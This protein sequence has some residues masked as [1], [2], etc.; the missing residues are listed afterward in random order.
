[1][2]ASTVGGREHDRSL[3]GTRTNMPIRF[4]EVLSFTIGAANTTSGTVDIRGHTFLGLRIP[5]SFTGTQLTFEVSAD[6]A[7]WNGLY[8]ITGAQ[9]V[10]PVVQGRAYDLP[11][12]VSAWPYF[13][14]VSSAT[15]GSN[16]ILTCV[17]KG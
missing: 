15:E 16:R 2:T 14:V 13:R 3:S 17:M 9:V 6:A 7:N 10:L 8:D 1:M 4:G 12:E 11:G 5:A